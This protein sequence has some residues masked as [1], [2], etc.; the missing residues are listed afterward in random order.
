MHPS[1]LN[2]I[3]QAADLALKSPSLDEG[4]R[5]LINA[6]SLFSE[7]SK[8]LENGYERLQE[9]FK[10]VHTELEKSNH[11]LRQKILELN[12]LSNYLNNILKNISQG[13]IFIDSEGIITTFNLAAE[14]ILEK[15]SSKILF[16][17]YWDHF[18]DDFFGFSIRHALAF[19]LSHH[20]TYLNLSLFE[21]HKKEIEVSASYVYDA[22]KKYQGIILLLRDVTKLQKLQSIANRND[23]MKELGEMAA[24]VAHEIRNPLGGIRGYA[25]LLF[26]DL[27]SSTHLQEMAAFIIEGTKTLE[28]LVNNVL[29]FSRPIHLQPTLID[30]GRFLK[31]ICKFMKVDPSFP[32]NVTLNLHLS[33][34]PLYAPIDKELL[35]S[36]LLNLFVNA[37]QAMEEKGGTL[38]LSLWK[39]NDACVITVADTGKGIESKDLEKIFSPFFTTKQKGTGLGLSEAYKIIQAH[40]GH[41]DVRSQLGAGSTFTVTLPLKRS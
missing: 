24:S 40:L 6:F 2:Q 17:N 14:G 15:E 28:R 9:R 25:S 39:N 20:L 8:R 34:E 11:S 13:L 23:R 7:E 32:E 3:Q 22:P 16:A 1:L 29:Q 38:T 5:H 18:S 12:T 33:Q 19:G 27:E 31:E 36:A 30:L 4:V 37:L 35:Q 10:E 26:R 41:I 21:S